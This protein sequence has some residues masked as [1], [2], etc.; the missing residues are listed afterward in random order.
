MIND[1]DYYYYRHVYRVVII[2]SFV[3]IAIAYSSASC[4]VLR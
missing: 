1:Y 3:N 4:N 2:I